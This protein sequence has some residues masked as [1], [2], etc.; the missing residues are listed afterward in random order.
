MTLEPLDPVFLE[1]L[2]LSEILRRLGFPPEAISPLVGA[3]GDPAMF[4]IVLDNGAQRW[5]AR[6]GRL[7]RKETADEDWKAAVFAWRVAL[8]SEVLAV[9]DRS[10]ARR[11]ATDIVVSLIDKG[12]RIPGSTA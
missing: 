7:R 9:F 5:Q 4:A 10:S 3:D 6:I 12:F 11:A 2:A 1:A 8:E